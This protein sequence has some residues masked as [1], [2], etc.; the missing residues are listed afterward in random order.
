MPVSF[1]GSILDIK[2][3]HD[4]WL[5]QLGLANCEATWLTKS[6]NHKIQK[7]KGKADQQ[8]HCILL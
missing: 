4:R 1:T 2:F 5:F 7:H 8:W 3:K 6:R